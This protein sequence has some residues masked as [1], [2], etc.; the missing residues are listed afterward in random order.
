MWDRRGLFFEFGVPVGEVDEALPAELTVGGDG[1]VEL[2]EPFGFGGGFAEVHVGFFGGAV[3]FSG[4]AGAAGEY[5]VFPGV[6]AAAGSGE[7]VV[8]G[9]FGFG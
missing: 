6:F 1:G 8:Y 9:E 2:G 3:A 4:V 5:E 7:Y